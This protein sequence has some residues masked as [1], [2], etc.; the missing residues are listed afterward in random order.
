[1]VAFGSNVKIMTGDP[2]LQ[3]IP[4]SD[5]PIEI[6]CHLVSSEEMSRLNTT[7]ISSVGSYAKS[8]HNRKRQ[9]ERDK[10]EDN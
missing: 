8:I 7:N 2:W 1:M 10:H 5:K 4:L 3:I 9:E 6:E